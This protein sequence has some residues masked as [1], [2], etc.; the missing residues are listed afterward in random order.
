MTTA[1]L[2]RLLDLVRQDLGAAD[3][4][5]EIGGLDPLDERLVWCRLA[6]GNR[7]VAVFPE[8]PADVA[9]VRDR[10]V[11]WAE[12]F[13]GLLGAAADLRSQTTSQA[14]GTRLER[15]LAR[16]VER[17]GAAGARIIDARSP[18]VWAAFEPRAND[19]EW[20][21]LVER[22][23]AEARQA[24][25][26]RRRYC[27]G[28]PG[29]GLSARRFAGIYILLVLFDGP[30]PELRAEGVVR[31][32]LGRIERLVLALPPADPPGGGRALRLVPN[33]GKA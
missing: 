32:A 3:A 23:T 10:L 1:P 7:L 14:A 2:L 5:V 24:L 12:S 8:R 6:T 19:T 26:R 11:A 28:E 21:Q 31:R 16:L 22:A 33:S 15:E 20:S 30:Y 18:V 4:R 17:A 25:D 9:E 13:E 27:V 29:F